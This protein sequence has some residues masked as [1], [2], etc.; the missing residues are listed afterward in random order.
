MIKKWQCKR[1]MGQTFPKSSWGLDSWR[2]Q[3]KGEMI[4]KGGE[5][6]QR[7][8]FRKLER[9]NLS[10]N[11]RKN[12][13]DFYLSFCPLN[14]SSVP[15]KY[16]SFLYKSLIHPLFVLIYCLIFPLWIVL[17]IFRNQLCRS[18]TSITV[19]YLV[20]FDPTILLISFHIFA[21]F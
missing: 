17:P 4:V 11:K 2:Q 8:G 20:V 5:R 19:P 7:R 1:M 21:I 16:R 14:Q 10:Q 6:Q 18:I 13:R 15:Q 3:R 9:E 12:Q